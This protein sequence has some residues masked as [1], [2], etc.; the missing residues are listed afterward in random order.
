MQSLEKYSTINRTMEAICDQVE[1]GYNYALE[2]CPKFENPEQ[3]FN[4][5]KSVTTYKRDPNG[6]EF[7]QSMPTLF[8]EV[9]HST[10]EVYPSGYGDCDCFT[11]TSLTCMKVQGEKWQD[12]GIVLV[13]RQ[14]RNPVHIYSYINFEGELY[15]FDLTNQ[16]IN[17]ERS[18]YKFRQ[19]LPV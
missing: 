10:G 4:W 13:G 6:Y 18:D 14:K 1:E 9:T 8:R 5:L 7:I 12:C 19:F 11:V 3:L 15:I 17:H 16:Y 2:H